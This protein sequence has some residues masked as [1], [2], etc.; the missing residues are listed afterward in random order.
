VVVTEE[1]EETAVMEVQVLLEVWVVPV[2]RLVPEV[3]QLQEE[4]QDLIREDLLI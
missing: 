2:E 1:L 3:L 4:S